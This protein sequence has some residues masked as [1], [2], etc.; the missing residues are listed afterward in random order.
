MLLNRY[1]FRQIATSF[2]IAAG[3]MLFIALPGI[4]VGAVHKLAGVGTAT[5]LK[6]LPMAA[7]NFV[8]FMLPIAFLLSVVATYGRLAADNEWTAIRMAGIR[9]ARMMTP[10]LGMGSL[11]A[12]VILLMN[13]EFGPWLTVRMKTFQQDAVVDMVKNLAPGRTEVQF[14]DFYLFAPFRE[15]DVFFDAFIEIPPFEGHSGM[16]VLAEEVRF[17]FTDEDM[18]VEMRNMQG[19]HESAEMRKEYLSIR[20]PLDSIV[21]TQPQFFI[22]ARYLRTGDLLRAIR[23][24]VTPGGDP[25]PEERYYRYTYE[26]HERLSNSLT[27]LMF[28][29][30]GVGTGILLRRGTQLAALA[31]SIGYAVL[32]WVL[33]LR[34][35]RELIFKGVIP[36]WAGTWG[37]LLVCTLGGVWLIRRAFRR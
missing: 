4:A 30:V 31:V 12:V 18:L 29:L 25:I 26:F 24:K 5:V 3:G 36:P 23:D 35:G 19:V 6:F 28:V 10:A 33:A 2:A 13:T 11:A 15:D 14:E 7:A 21:Q 32:Y 16:T 22:D 20:V 27:C 1:I 34:L 8:P 37:P 9:P 17:E